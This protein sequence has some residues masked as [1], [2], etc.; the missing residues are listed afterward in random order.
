MSNDNDQ[1]QPPPSV[2]RT[3]DP[4]IK[5]PDGRKIKHRA[6]YTLR[7][8]LKYRHIFD[9][10]LDEK[11][12]KL[13]NEQGCNFYTLRTKI[14]DALRWLIDNLDKESV[15][16]NDKFK[17]SNIDYARLRRCVQISPV[18]NG[19]LIRYDDSG[20]GIN[21]GKAATM[22]TVRDIKPER[23]KW[24]EELDMYLEKPDSSEMFFKSGILISNDDRVEVEQMLAK[25]A[26]YF[27]WSIKENSITLVRK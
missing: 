23:K 15:E 5:T 14:S 8:A 18:S 27:E 22:T 16:G 10:I 17:Y 6:T 21:L 12:S 13:V 19:V 25:Y 1:A 11:E 4:F 26:D 24:R 9:S 7:N 20:I 3:F 2:L